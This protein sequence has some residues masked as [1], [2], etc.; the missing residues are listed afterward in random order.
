MFC[1]DTVQYNTRTCLLLEDINSGILCEFV[2]FPF[3]LCK[4]KD[5]SSQTNVTLQL[6]KLV[7]AKSICQ[8][9]K[10]GLL[11]GM[12]WATSLGSAASLGQNIWKNVKKSSKVRQNY[13]ALIS[14]F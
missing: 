4:L 14:T 3:V 13:K 7:V 5:S 9:F 10:I 8:T 6:V 1:I 11:V 12:T 2:S